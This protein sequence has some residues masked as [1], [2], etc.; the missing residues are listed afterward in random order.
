MQG[1]RAT[2][3]PMR[4]AR[5]AHE[6]KKRQDRRYYLRGR[7][8]K[9]SGGGAYLATLTGSQSSAVLMA[10]HLGDC[11][12]VLPE[13]IGVFPAGMEVGPMRLDMEEGTP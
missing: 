12:I 6:V 2:E 7:V 8:E 9:D 11:L 13:G 10:A 5:L 3:Y 4:L 1:F